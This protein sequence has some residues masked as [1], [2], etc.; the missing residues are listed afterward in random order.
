MTEPA[1]PPLD[2]DAL[3]A[4]ARRQQDTERKRVERAEAAKARALAADVPAVATLRKMPA[5]PRDIRRWLREAYD[6]YEAGQ[7][8]SARLEQAR[9]HA[10]AVCDVFRASAELRKATAAIRSAEAQ[11]RMAELLAA[12]EHGGAVVGLLASLR[13]GDGLLAGPRRPLPRPTTAL[14]PGVPAEGDAS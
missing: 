4:L 14:R 3:D 2:T 7:R 13:S 12:V 6:Q 11:E 5:S 10:R 9:A 8:T 1:P